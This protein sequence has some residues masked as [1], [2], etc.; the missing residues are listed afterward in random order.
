MEYRGKI[1]AAL[2]GAVCCLYFSQLPFYGALVG[3]AIGHYF[4]DKKRLSPTDKAYKVFKDR[5]WLFLQHAFSLSAKVAKAKGSVN[6][7]EIK[8]MER[9]ITHQFK[10]K[11]TARTQAIAH[12]N[13]AKNSP[14]SFEEFALDFQRSFGSERHQIVNMMD[15]LIGVAACDQSLHPKEEAVLLKA[16]AI[17]RISR[18]QYERIRERHIAPPKLEKWTP[19]DPHYAILGAHPQDDLLTIKQK[20]RTLVKKWHPDTMNANNASKESLRHASKK[21]QEIKEA[22]EMILART[23]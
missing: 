21:F 17:F 9:M 19:L 4:I 10:L 20:Y 8:F 13:A 18:M 14:R 3:L 16:S 6:A 15:L 7:T 12:W 23:G 2:I 1:M 22:Y 11:D 5:E